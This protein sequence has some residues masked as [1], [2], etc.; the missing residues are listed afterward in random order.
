M[1]LS[2]AAEVDLGYDRLRDEGEQVNDG[3]KKQFKHNFC[4]FLKMP[5]Y[6]L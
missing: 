2:C 1:G 5:G 4:L 6:G 3:L